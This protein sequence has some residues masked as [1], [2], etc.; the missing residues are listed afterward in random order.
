[1]DVKALVD[2]R[3]IK[4]LDTG[5]ANTKANKRKT[6]KRSKLRIKKIL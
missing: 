6:L 5:A 3:R 1:M 4:S 2:K